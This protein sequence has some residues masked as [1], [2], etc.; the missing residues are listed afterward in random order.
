MEAER[1]WTESS[2]CGS[3]YSGCRE[4]TRAI[5]YPI[6]HSRS[7]ALYLH[8]ANLVQRWLFHD[9]HNG[10]GHACREQQHSIA[11]PFHITA[12]PLHI[13]DQH[14][15]EHH[16]TIDRGS[17]SSDQQ[18]VSLLTVFAQQQLHYWQFHGH[19]RVSTLRIIIRCCLCLIELCQHGL[20]VSQLS[21]SMTVC[22]V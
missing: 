11:N 6:S 22:S 4:T 20:Q 19:G 17:L 10:R 7:L 12:Q 14:S 3:N 8:G 21:S 18:I 2:L 5:E 9:A 15:T 1:T 16:N 13:T